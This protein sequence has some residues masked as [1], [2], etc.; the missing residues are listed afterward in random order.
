VLRSGE[1]DC[2]LIAKDDLA[3][4]QIDRTPACY[5]TGSSSKAPG[6]TR[7]SDAL[8]IFCRKQPRDAGWVRCGVSIGKK[9]CI[10]SLGYP[11][12]LD[13]EDGTAVLPRCDTED[14]YSKAP[15]KI[16]GGSA[17]RTA[18]YRWCTEEVS[19]NS[20]TNLPTI[21]FVALG[22]KTRGRRRSKRNESGREDPGRHDAGQELRQ[23]SL[24]RLREMPRPRRAIAGKGSHLALEVFL[25]KASSIR[26]SGLSK[27]AHT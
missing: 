19:H 22:K 24:K 21:I 1:A 20:A 18:T 15:S 6:S 25:L 5:I 17:Q 4:A 9:Y 14:N 12:V 26:Y 7:D 10:A 2:P 13:V 3:L 23:A 27:R 11:M 16:A 8:V